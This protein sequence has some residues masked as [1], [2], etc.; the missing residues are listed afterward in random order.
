MQTFD[1]KKEEDLKNATDNVESIS[2]IL[3]LIY[4]DCFY[5]CFPDESVSVEIKAE[6]ILI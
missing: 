2:A 4:F 1:G 3:N 6:H 5:S